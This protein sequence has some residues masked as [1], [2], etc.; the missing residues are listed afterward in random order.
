MGSRLEL[1]VVYIEWLRASDVIRTGWHL[2]N[3]LEPIGTV[4]KPQFR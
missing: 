2:F 1:G 3:E 4:S